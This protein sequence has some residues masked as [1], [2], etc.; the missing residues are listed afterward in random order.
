MPLLQPD[1]DEYVWLVP[2]HWPLDALSRNVNLP[3]A[4]FF[5]SKRSGFCEFFFTDSMPFMQLALAL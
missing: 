5:F 1:S 2:T 4:V 3:D